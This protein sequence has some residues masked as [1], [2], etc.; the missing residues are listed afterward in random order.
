[1][2]GMEVFQLNCLRQGIELEH[3]PDKAAKHDDASFNQVV[4]MEMIKNNIKKHEIDKKERIKRENRKKVDADEAK[5]K[6]DML[7]TE[8]NTVE[9]YAKQMSNHFTKCE[10]IHK[11]TLSQQAQS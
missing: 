4:V 2:D 3:D 5:I 10:F 7:W 9:E 8:N 1:V 11:E 6:S